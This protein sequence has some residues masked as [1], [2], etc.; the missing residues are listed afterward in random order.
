VWWTDSSAGRLAIYDKEFT[1]RNGS[2]GG[3]AW[4]IGLHNGLLATGGMVGA[5]D[6]YVT[7][8]E[9][10]EA[11]LED[12]PSNFLF[13]TANSLAVRFYPGSTSDTSWADKVPY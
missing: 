8:R 12:T 9:D 10:V 5:V 1:G 11:I 2:P 4:V 7:R 6:N 13:K 3:L